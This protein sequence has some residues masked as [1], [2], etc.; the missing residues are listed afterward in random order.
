MGIEAILEDTI[1]IP[2]T[3]KTPSTM[4]NTDADSTPTVTFYENGLG[5]AMGI[6]GT[7]VNRTPAG[8]YA[9]YVTLSA[10]NGFEAGK[11]YEMWVTATI[12]GTVYGPEPVAVFKVTAAG[13]D[14]LSAQVGSIGSGIGAALNFAA[15]GDN[16]GGAIKGV[17]FVG[18]QTGTYADTAAHD[19]NTHNI[20]DVGSVIDIVYSFA[21]GSARAASTAFWRGWV[22]GVNDEVT[23]SAYNFL[24]SSWDVRALIEGVALAAEGV[25]TIP[26]LSA[27]TGTS[28]AD[29]GLVLLRFQSTDDTALVTDELY[30]QA[31]LSGSQV[32]YSQGAIWIDGPNGTAGTL[33]FVNGV[34]DHPVDS[35]A[36][37][38]TLA[39]ALEIYRFQVAPG[40]T[41]TLTADVKRYAMG[42]KGWKLELGGFDAS[43]ATFDGC[44]YVTGTAT[45]VDWEMFFWHCQFGDATLAEFDMHNCHITGT[46][47]LSEA[48][49]YLLNG[50]VG[51]PDP[52]ATIN[53]ASIGGATVVMGSARGSWTVSNMAVGDTLYVDGACQLTLDE[54]CL[55]GTVILTNDISLTDASTGV[56]VV[57]PVSEGLIQAIET[58]IPLADTPLPDGITYRT[59]RPAL[60][61]INTITWASGRVFVY[62]YDSAGRWIGVTPF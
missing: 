27:H 33:P 44:E 47:T 2:F 41:I 32:G 36:D 8:C 13:L 48:A 37:A 24:T 10:A 62:Q 61:K 22:A 35:W 57:T 18:S 55:G 56:V 46:I 60:G 23:V 42:G 52:G 20:A 34:A 28:G 58:T 5:T 40:T 15:S 29:M 11:Y 50:C 26:L 19:D 43:Y 6:A 12:G 31:Q 21:V 17:S 54:T 1:Y 25:Q 38:L 7:V 4:V 16:T 45:A 9:A 39:G 53:F 49:P 51:V 3:T 59:E 14:S 30:I